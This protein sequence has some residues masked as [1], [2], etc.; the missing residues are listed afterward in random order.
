MVPHSVGQDRKIVFWE[1]DPRLLAS[2]G[3]GVLFQ[4]HLDGETDEG[5]AISISNCGRYLATGG[6]AGVIRVW[7][8]PSGARICEGNGHNAAIN[9]VAFSPNDKQL[10]SGAA[11]GA[12]IVWYLDFNS[13]SAATLI[14]GGT[15][16][17]ETR[18]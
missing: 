8:Y 11:D 7:A 9:S 16:F 1:N 4:Q 2:N 5:L 17:V 18:M 6:T 13:S 10:I 12:I 15:S 3:T 14:N